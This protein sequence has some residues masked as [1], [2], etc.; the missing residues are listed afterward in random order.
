MLGNLRQ[1]LDEERLAALGHERQ[2][3]GDLGSRDVMLVLIIGDQITELGNVLAGERFG[4]ALGKLALAQLVDLIRAGK[5]HLLDRLAGRLFNGAQQV[6][7]PRS[8]KQ[9]RVAGAART[10][11][12]ANTVH[13]GLGVVRD[14]VVDNQGDALDVESTGSDVGGDQDVDLA[15]TQRLDGALALLLWNVAIDRRCAVAAG[16]ELVGQVFGCH[17]GAHEGQHAAVF[18]DLK[19]AGQCI[20]L[21]RTHD[22]QVALAGVGAGGGLGLDRDF[23]GIVQVLLRDPADLGR[24]GGRE[25]R[26]LLVVRGPGEDLLHVFGEAHPQHFIGLIEDQV[27]QLGQVERALVDVVDHAAGGSDDDLCATA[28]AVQLGTVGRTAVNGQHGE[29]F[30]VCGVGGECLGNLQGQFAGRSQHQDLGGLRRRQVGHPG[31]RGNRECRGFTGTGLGQ[32]NDVAAFQQCRNGGRL[33]GR[34][35]FIADVG[36]RCEDAGVNAEIGETHLGLFGFG[37]CSFRRRSFGG[38]LDV[39]VVA[40]QELPH[41]YG[42]MASRQVRRCTKKPGLFQSLARPRITTSGLRSRQARVTFSSRRR[43]HMKMPAAA[44]P[45]TTNLSQYYD[46]GRIKREYRCGGCFQSTLRF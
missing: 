39:V 38:G 21:V 29:V 13:I 30:Q 41:S 32:P 4:D 20:E 1:L 27:L 6:L 31:Q 43:S 33:D 25:E 22:L 15:V 17:L 11:G 14:V 44:G 16:P 19:N 7:L 8:H 12:A 24:H 5:V 18:L 37:G 46:L 3:G 23:G 10:A 35:L 45:N 34:R 2:R 9:D 40:G 42:L 36:Q 28:Q 26:H